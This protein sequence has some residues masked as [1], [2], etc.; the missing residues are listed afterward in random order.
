MRTPSV[1]I[2][3]YFVPKL[4]PTTLT[5]VWSI[6]PQ[7]TFKVAVLS[8]ATWLRSSKNVIA[9]VFR[10]L[11]GYDA[12]FHQQI[13]L[14]TRREFVSPVLKTWFI[15]KE[16]SSPCWVSSSVWLSRFV[17]RPRMSD[18]LREES[19]ILRQQSF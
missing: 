9:T 2:E 11:L 3:D 7:R 16:C 12:H 5:S 4:F 10:C 18:M 13:C 19:V 14:A 17:H 15:Q 6:G 1:D 8:A